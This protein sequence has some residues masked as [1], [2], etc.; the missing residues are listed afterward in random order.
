MLLKPPSVLTHDH[1]GNPA[2]PSSAW[3]PPADRPRALLI[4]AAASALIQMGRSCGGSKGTPNVHL[5]PQYQRRRHELPL[6]PELSEL[7]R[8]V[9]PLDGPPPGGAAVSRVRAARARRV[10]R[11]VAIRRRP[12][13]RPSG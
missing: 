8:D 7:S 5:R 2:H 4:N 12:V 9:Q 10:V 11:P 6:V 13:R 3:S 1:H